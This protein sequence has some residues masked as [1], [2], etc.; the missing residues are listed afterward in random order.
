MRL[1]QLRQR[2][3]QVDDDLKS[4][5]FEHWY[6]ISDL[7]SGVVEGSAVYE[8]L[9]K[10][11]KLAEAKLVSKLRSVRSQVSSSFRIIVTIRHLPIQVCPVSHH[12]IF[13]FSPVG[14]SA[15]C[16][17]QLD[18]EAVSKCAMW[19]WSLIFDLWFDY[20]L[21]RNHGYCETH[22]STLHLLCKK[23]CLCRSRRDVRKHKYTNT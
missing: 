16:S 13:D 3:I 12:L 23:T 21:L 20:Y 10:K 4:L 2:S 9:L 22:P 17:M 7:H 15:V 19:R 1:P 5:S 6:L 14:S 11:L 8:E 18:V